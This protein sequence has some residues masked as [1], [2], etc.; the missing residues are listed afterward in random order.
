MDRIRYRRDLQQWALCL[1]AACGRPAGQLS[2]QLGV[3]AQLRRQLRRQLRLQL[4]QALAAAAAAPARALGLQLRLHLDPE[5]CTEW[6]Q[7]HPDTHG[8]WFVPHLVLVVLSLVNQPAFLLTRS[9]SDS[10]IRLIRLNAMKPAFRG[11]LLELF[12]KFK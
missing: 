1:P 11:N 8:W 6:E 3:D 10:F 9:V 12:I 7:E 2:G 5:D 4:G